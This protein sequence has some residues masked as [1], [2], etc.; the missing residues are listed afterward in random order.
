MHFVNVSCRI[1]CS[2]FR[3]PCAH[4]QLSTSR[5][6]LMTPQVSAERLRPT[7]SSAASAPALL[8][9]GLPG[10]GAE[11]VALEGAAEIPGDEVRQREANH[12]LDAFGLPLACLIAR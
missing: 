1:I 5:S 9:R 2:L 10:C 7:L 8:Q 4:S 6:D 3:S 12:F 11:V